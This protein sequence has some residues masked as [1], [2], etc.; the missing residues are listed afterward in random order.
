MS[1]K[2]DAYCAFAIKPLWLRPSAAMAVALL[3]AGVVIGAPWPSS[4]DLAVSAPLTVQVIPGGQ[5]AEEASAPKQVQV[6][7]VTAVD[8]P[9]VDSQASQ[10][11]SPNEVQ[12]ASPPQ[13]VVLAVEPTAEALQA[14]ETREVDEKR[15]TKN[16]PIRTKRKDKEHATEA[17][18]ARARSHARAAAQSPDSTVTGSVASANYRSLVAAELNRRKFYPAAARSSGARGVVLVNFTVGSSGHVTQHS[19]AR[20]SGQPALDQA[21]HQMMA[22]VSLPP[23]PGGVFRAS[24][25]IH[26]DFAH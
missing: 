17:A 4:S 16:A 19:I 15:V 6:A 23:P 14:A 24:V 26:F 8:K 3:H 21:V 11:K 2:P 5:K 18:E 10:A 7:E 9:S 1:S 13:R 20:S 22:S 12:A 25:P